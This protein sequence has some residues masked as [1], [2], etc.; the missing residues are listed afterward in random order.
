MK[1]ISA[2]IQ[3]IA[4]THLPQV[5]ALGNRHFRVFKHDTE[6]STVT[7]VGELSAD[8]RVEE[9]AK[10]LSGSA[11]DAAAT[12]NARALLSASQTH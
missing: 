1:E 12:A 6:T 2:H 5:A 8:E 9:I 4:I 3:V 7:S 11:V 10:M